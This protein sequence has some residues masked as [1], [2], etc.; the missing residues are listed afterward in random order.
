MVAMA[1]PSRKNLLNSTSVDPRELR[2]I[3]ITA[4]ALCPATT[5]LEA[6]TAVPAWRSMIFKDIQS[7]SKGLNLAAVQ[8]AKT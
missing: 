3:L 2:I 1:G 5:C 4:T 6:V 7:Y 8:R